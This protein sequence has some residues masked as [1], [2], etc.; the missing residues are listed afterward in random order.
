MRPS[1]YD[2]IHR[3]IKG[4][5][6]ITL[7]EDHVR[8]SARKCY[9]LTSKWRKTAVNGNLPDQKFDKQHRLYGSWQAMSVDVTFF[10]TVTPC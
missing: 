1:N 4:M 8:S 5:E 7:I 10:R 3:D 9:R 2:L 6:S